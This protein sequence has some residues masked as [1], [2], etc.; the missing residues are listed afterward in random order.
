MEP[1]RTRNILA[2][3]PFLRFGQVG[4]KI[5]H[6]SEEKNSYHLMN[7]SQMSVAKRASL[8]KIPFLSHAIVLETEV[9][10]MSDYLKAMKEAV[11]KHSNKDDDEREIVQF[12]YGWVY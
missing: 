3:N 12:S 5:D 10:S 11:I 8:R 4:E 2:G 7:I 6:A 1:R 9:K